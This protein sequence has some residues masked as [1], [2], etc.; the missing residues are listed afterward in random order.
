MDESE[1]QLVPPVVG[2]IATTGSTSAN[3]NQNVARITAEPAQEPPAVSVTTSTAV[4]A[5]PD[6]PSSATGT[7]RPVEFLRDLPKKTGVFIGQNGIPYATMTDAPNRYALAV[8]SR[9]LNNFIRKEAL[10]AGLALKNK[11]ISEINDVLKAHAEMA[12]I[13]KNVFYRSAPI[14]GGVQLD[15]GDDQHTRISITAGKVE[16]VTEDSEVIFFR[17]AASQPL[18]LPAELGNIKLLKKYLNM[19]DEAAVLFIA[20]LTYTIAHPKVATSKF[21]ILVLMGNQGS[22]KSLLCR[23]ILRLL[24]PSMIGIQVMPSNVKDLAIAA[25]NAHV[26]CYDNLRDI[27]QWMADI[28][29]IAATGGSMASRQL[30]TD[31]DLQVIYLHVALVL[32]GIHSFIDQPDLAQ[33]C[34]PLQ[35]ITL[36]EGNR[37]SEVQLEKELLGDLPSIMRGLYELIASIFTHLPSVQVT[38]PERMIDFVYWL[39]AFEA[40]QGVPTGVYQTAY[41][42]AL[43]QGQLDSLLDNPLAA[44]VIQFAEDYDDDEWE[45]TPADFLARLNLITSNGTQRSRDW[46]QNPIALSKRLIPLQAGLQSQGIGVQLGR[47]KNRTITV[48]VKGRNHD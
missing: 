1:L 35:L 32:N 15:V 22:G 4:V 29:C 38:N 7:S 10:K 25:Q 27:K 18:A 3:S 11:D 34:L 21:L 33:R 2:D 28:L 45:G 9:A 41:S 24:D 26:L 8:G 20:W 23:L 5:K 19:R 48:A 12:G 44:A 46:P 14:D 17:T 39:A 6:V 47:G 42:D 13:V 31:A 16:T 30:Y 36:P 40:A 43:Q 37:K